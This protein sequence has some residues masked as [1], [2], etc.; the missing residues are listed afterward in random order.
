MVLSIQ[1]FTNRDF[2]E[3]PD[4]ANQLLN[5]LPGNELQNLLIYAK[6][7]ILPAKKTIHNPYKA[8]E[9]VYFPIRGIISLL[10]ISQEGLVAESATVSNEGII[11]LAGFLGGNIASN[12]AIAQTECIVLS[13]PINI[14]RRELAR[15]GELQRILL[16]YSQALLAQISQNVLCSCHHTLEQRLAR[17]LIFYSDRLSRKQ[18]LLTQ[19]TLAD[20]LGVRR[21][22]L[23]IV[24]GDLRKRKLIDYSRGR[25]LIE[26]P[27]ALRKVACQCD[28]TILNEYTRLVTTPNANY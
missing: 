14:L 3:I 6:R 22:S 26:N 4:R 5:L 28:R 24:A 15:N 18:L 13:L 16:L 7:I 20:L 27:V 21:S 12:W 10:N 1:H 23:S 11:G 8:I 2:Q 17:W 9:K 25:I 19:E